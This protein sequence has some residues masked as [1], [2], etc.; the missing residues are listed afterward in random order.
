VLIDL[1]TPTD[2]I[3]RSRRS[4]RLEGWPRARSG[5]F[6]VRDRATQLLTTRDTKH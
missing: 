3:L 2:L 5:A 4:L 1:I 6:M